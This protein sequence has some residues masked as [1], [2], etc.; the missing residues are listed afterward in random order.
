MGDKKY[1]AENSHACMVFGALRTC[2]L[3]NCEFLSSEIILYAIILCNY[4]NNIK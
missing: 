1:S 4:T 3:E 2:L